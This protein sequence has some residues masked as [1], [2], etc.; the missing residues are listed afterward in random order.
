M[1]TQGG[2]RRSAGPYSQ[3]PPGCRSSSATV[4]SIVVRLLFTRQALHVATMPRVLSPT[5]TT[6]GSVSGLGSTRPQSSQLGCA[7]SAAG[8]STSTLNT[9]RARRSRQSRHAGAGWSET[10]SNTS[11]TTP[12]GSR[13]KVQRRTFTGRPAAML[14][15]EAAPRP[16]NALGSR[17]GT[18]RTG[19]R[20][21]CHPTTHRPADEL[22]AHPDDVLPWHLGTSC[23]SW[24]S[25][26]PSSSSRSRDA[27]RSCAL[28]ANSTMCATKTRSSCRID[29]LRSRQHL[30][31][32]ETADVLGI[33]EVDLA[34]PKEL[35]E[36]RLDR[37]DL[38]ARLSL[39]L[40]LHKHVDVAVGTEVVA[41]HG[42]EEGHAADAVTTAQR[43]KVAVREV[44]D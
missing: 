29:L 8:S 23:S 5:Q 39:R 41:Q 31:L 40:E 13:Q 22:V 18:P 9:L 15:E 28:R 33:D 16:G 36:L 30:I 6:A 44:D 11:S 38:E 25:S 21:T 24:R 26:S 1:P 3:S 42:A 10:P 20:A 34:S 35:G 4:T 19:T 14:R 12:T 43:G 17:R 37:H 32:E 7:G 27:T 2:R